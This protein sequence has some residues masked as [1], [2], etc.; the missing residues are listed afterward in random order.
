MENHT[1]Y[2]TQHTYR[3][4][5]KSKFIRVT[6]KLKEMKSVYAKTLPLAVSY[7]KQAPAQDSLPESH[8]S[9]RKS[10]KQNVRSFCFLK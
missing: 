10:N 8:E 3:N 7:V 1:F 6:L 4:I 9:S 5:K 2:N